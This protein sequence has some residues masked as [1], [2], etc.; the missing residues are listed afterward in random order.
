MGAAHSKKGQTIVD[1]QAFQTE[2]QQQFSTM[3]EALARRNGDARCAP[4]AAVAAVAY[5]G[6][7][8]ARLDGCSTEHYRLSLGQALVLA[9]R[10]I[11]PELVAEIAPP[12]GVQH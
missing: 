4:F 11:A 9:T 6:K 2:V 7:A 1:A 8:I 12:S 10:E 5:L 3:L